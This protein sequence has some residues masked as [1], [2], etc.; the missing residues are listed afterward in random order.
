MKPHYVCWDHDQAFEVLN[1]DAE[2]IDDAVFL[3]VHT[4]RPLVLLPSPRSVEQAQTTKGGS[5]LEATDF[6]EQ[7]LDPARNHVQA[8]VVGSAGTGKSHLIHWMRL[9]IPRQDDR[10][11]ITI[12]RSG[13]SLRGILQL[14]IDQLPGE[15]RDLYVARLA[16]AGSDSDPA[17]VR[18][19]RL[20]ANVGLAIRAMEPAL[21]DDV[22]GWLLPSRLAYLFQDPFLVRQLAD[23]GGIFA[24]LSDHVGELHAYSRSETVRAFDFP[25]FR[26]VGADVDRLAEPTREVVPQLIANA[27][28]KETATRLVNEAIPRA[29]SA[30]LN[31]TGDQLIELMGDVRRYVRSRNQEIVLLIEDFARLQGIDQALL[32]ALLVRH[33]DNQPD[34]A[35]LRWAMA[36]TRG[37]WAARIPDTVQ[38]RM[39]FV[40][41]MDGSLG[42][43]RGDREGEVVSFAARY[44]NAVRIP[45]AQ[46]QA[47]K[48][49]GALEEAPNK[50]DR[51]PQRD[52]CHAAFGRVGE[53]GLYPFNSSSLVRMLVRK[54]NRFP[55]AFNP[56]SLVGPV[57]K[58]VLGNRRQEF[59]DGLFPSKSFLE[60]MGGPGMQAADV[61]WITD[62]APAGES[63]RHV[64]TVSLWGDGS[65]AASA[66]VRA[67]LGLRSL[68]GHEIEVVETADDSDEPAR[69]TNERPRSSLEL[70]LDKWGT[71]APL[72]ERFGR[73]LREY[74]FEAIVASTEWDA[75]GLERET[76]AKPAGGEFFG[77]RR[78]SFQNQEVAAEGGPVALVIPET[79]DGEAILDASLAL[80]ALVSLRLTGRVPD[81]DPRMYHL[82]LAR[83]LAH[84][85]GHVVESLQRLA[86]ESRDVRARSYARLLLLG[87][88]LAGVRR[89]GDG[90]ADWV[91]AVFGDWNTKI[92]PASEVWIRALAEVTTARDKAIDAYLALS[93]ASK[94]GVARAAIDPRAIL[95]ELEQL[96]ACGWRPQPAASAA[97][98][99]DDVFPQLEQVLRRVSGSVDQIL[100]EEWD[101]QRAWRERTVE[102]IPAETSAAEV[103][104]TVIRL[105]SELVRSKIGYSQVAMDLLLRALDAMNPGE[106]DRARVDIWELMTQEVAP[107]L[108]DLVEVE[109]LQAISA[110][111]TVAARLATLARET[112][113]AFENL[114]LTAAAEGQLAADHLSIRE[115][116]SMIV[117][118]A[119]EI[120]G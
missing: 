95:M 87:A 118:A 66:G 94:G 54:D 14:L 21:D 90:P 51:C 103:R 33:S 35:P 96:H 16:E 88:A 119:A 120:G 110:W 69:G 81:S 9:N 75:L 65:R 41:D 85:T 89:E 70:A 11:V 98:G 30:V 53:V 112:T 71:G 44:L 8:A 73:Q 91:R 43:S 76:F 45:D 106:V 3:A 78:I 102:E 2:A 109:R 52:D 22:E 82:Q 24:Q 34:L 18:L 107:G 36:V 1:P 111:N 97:T 64:A 74:V 80:Q 5:R 63:D 56:R 19:Q 108:P 117:R 42:E 60:G 6:L 37:Y 13:T 39:D 7:F 93:A 28:V 59:D 50:C 86:G 29:I 49:G 62:R 115:R 58:E 57:L 38:E 61:R 20:I 100:D 47:W 12:P 17:P 26:I 25:D 83:H 68:G 46:L 10:I 15:E 104:A 79:D 32:Q 99:K 116:L 101:R 105:R 4:D 84:W 23:E 114:S 92:A 48:D 55:G 40:I 31:F 67:A 113:T 72:P 77:I 27:R